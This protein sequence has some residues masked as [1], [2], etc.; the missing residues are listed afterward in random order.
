MDAKIGL[1]GY[2]SM[3]T[4]LAK[5]LTDNLDKINWI[6]TNSDIIES[7]Q[8]RNNNYKYLPYVDLDLDKLNLISSIESGIE[9]SDIL[10][11]SIP[12]AYLDGVISK[13][14]KSLFSNKKIVVAIKGLIPE[15]N[16]PLHKYFEQI[17]GIPL[18]D[19]LSI[20]GPSH[21][22]EIVMEHYTDLILVSKNP[23]MYETIYPL[24]NSYF[25]HLE[26]DENIELAEYAAVVKNIYAILAGM[27][28]GYGLGDNFL[29]ILVTKITNEMKDFL[30]YFKNDVDID[31]MQPLYLGD[32]LVTIYSQFS[33]NRSF[34]ILLGKGYSL[35][36]SKIE[37]KQTVEGY[38]GIFTLA[39]ILGDDISKFPLISI[40]YR[41]LSKQNQAI[42]EIK[43]LL[44][45]M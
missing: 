10:F 12:A 6:I 25:L 15:K 5:V 17:I 7:L 35:E 19:Y 41:V 4:A 44:K 24:L 1:I 31:I 3:A 16:L 21:A 2:G 30:K 13:V 22:E 40:V 33:R 23:K 37:M 36:Y 45:I 8:T 20:L 9:Q 32:L 18:T 39:N 34:G 11:I 43:N 38:Y 27:C 28:I 14:D 42:R 26:Y 29:S